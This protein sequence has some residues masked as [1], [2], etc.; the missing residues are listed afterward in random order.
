MPD[1]TKGFN[2]NMKGYSAREL[3]PMYVEGV[4]IL[5]Y[6]LEVSVVGCYVST[7][8]INFIGNTCFW[9]EETGQ[10]RVCT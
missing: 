3:L 2:D 8:C 9:S 6:V 7:K 1:D 5:V 10:Y 4:V